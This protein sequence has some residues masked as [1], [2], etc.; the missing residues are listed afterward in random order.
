MRV[1]GKRGGIENKGERE[2]HTADGAA[3][4][5]KH[6]KADPKNPNRV[7]KQDEKRPQSQA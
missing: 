7:I 6:L 3:A 4:P 2:T 1:A 5:F